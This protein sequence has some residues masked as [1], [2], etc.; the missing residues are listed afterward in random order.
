MKQEDAQKI[1]K[2]L[3]DEWTEERG[4]IVPPETLPS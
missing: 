2:H 4:I 1:V 3:C